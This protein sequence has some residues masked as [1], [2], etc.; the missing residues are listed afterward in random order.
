MRFLTF[1]FAQAGEVKTSALATYKTIRTGLNR[2]RDV[3]FLTSA[4]RALKK[5]AE[6]EA[7]SLAA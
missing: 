5:C 3:S 1:A 2:T 6:V 7:A 4:L